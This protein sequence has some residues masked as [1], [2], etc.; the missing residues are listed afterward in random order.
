MSFQVSAAAYGRFMGRFSEPLAPAFLTWVGI[1]SGSRALDVGAGPGALTRPLVD[2]LG[3]D[4]VVAADPSEPFVASLRAE[5]P[6]L[7]VRR[8][9]AEALPFED[10]AFDVTLAQL[11]VHF[12][13]DP[14]LGLR[15]MSRVTRPGGTVAASVW[16]HTGQRGPFAGFSRVVLALDPDAPMETA[17]PGSREGELGAMA[18]QAGLVDVQETGLTVSLRFDD[19]DDWWAPF[20][21]GVGP[22]GDYV[23]G[24]SGAHRERL[25]QRLS[26]EVGP[27]PFTI[28]A[29]AWCVRGRVSGEA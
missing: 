3:S 1:P 20:L 14:V 4:A 15:E 11:V 9:P 13:S 16:D 19:F 27:A 26:D 8:A 22:A 18:D 6:E 25:R 5:L 23:A 28:S 12:M 29:T 2:L 21:L 10:G 7:D 17:L 24:L